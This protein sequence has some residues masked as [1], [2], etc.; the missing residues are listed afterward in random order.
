MHF[1]S[2]R[3]YL[4]IEFIFYQLQLN[5]Y[6]VLLT[7]NFNYLASVSW[8]CILHLLVV[9]SSILPVVPW[10]NDRETTISSNRAVEGLPTEYRTTHYLFLVD[11][12]HSR[13]M[14]ANERNISHFAHT[15][16]DMFFVFIKCAPQASSHENKKL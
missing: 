4:N 5:V 2:P 12:T 7:G 10:K 14:F 1:S 6:F 9:F 13:Y 16:Y 8:R 15:P 3:H 11:H